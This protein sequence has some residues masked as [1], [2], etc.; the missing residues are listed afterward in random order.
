MY[1][2]IIAD[3]EFAEIHSRPSYYSGEENALSDIEISKTTVGAAKSLLA[4]VYLTMAGWPLNK[5]ELRITKKP[6][7]MRNK[8]LTQD[9]IPFW[10]TIRNYL[11]RQTKTIRK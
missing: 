3:L 5:K 4:K 10:M 1:E 11:H 9:I 7:I 8:L 6:K 2:Q